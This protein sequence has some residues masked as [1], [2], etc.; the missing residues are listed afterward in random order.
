MG[1]WQPTHRHFKGDLY[2]LIGYGR[3]EETLEEVAVYDG[4]GGSPAFGIWVRPRLMFDGRME[5]GRRRFEPI[6]RDPDNA[7]R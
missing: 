2:R 5:D 3:Q 1:E 7:G 4:P 6:K